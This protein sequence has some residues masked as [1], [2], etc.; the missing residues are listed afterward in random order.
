[1]QTLDIQAV[2][3]PTL[4]A[5][6]DEIQQGFDVLRRALFQIRDRQL[7]AEV[8]DGYDNPVYES[9]EHY[10]EVR[11]QLGRS[12]ANNYALAGRVEQEML[13]AGASEYQLP[14]KVEHG[15]ALKDVEPSDRLEVLKTAQ[16]ITGGQPTTEAIHQARKIVRPEPGQKYEVVEPSN[17]Y[18]GET[19]TANEVKGNIVMGLERAYPFLP[20]ELRPIDPAPIPTKPITPSIRERL[21]SCEALLHEALK[22]HL[23]SDLQARIE[24]VLSLG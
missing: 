20:G 3:L 13:A 7:W 2:Q 21:K 14:R 17:P 22:C 1:M 8:T 4:E 10:C 11:W 24:A 5:L 12:Q 16:Q 23:P 18:H 9:F 19:I 15:I 6:E